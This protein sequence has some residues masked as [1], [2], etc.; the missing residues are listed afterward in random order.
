MFTNGLNC[1]KKNEIIFKVKT[2]QAG[3]QRQ[4]HKGKHTWN[5]GFS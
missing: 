5:G 4:A 3:P 1:F 2:G